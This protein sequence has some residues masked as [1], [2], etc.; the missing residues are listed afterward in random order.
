MCN[1]DGTT[2]YSGSGTKYW[3]SIVD[4]SGLTSTL[5]TTLAAGYTPYKMIYQ[6]ANPS[7]Y[8]VEEGI[9]PQILTAY[10]SGTVFIDPAIDVVYTYTDKITFA[11]KVKSLEHIEKIDGTA[12]TEIAT[13]SA[14]LAADGMSM[15][16]SGATAGTKYRVVALTL[17]ESNAGISL[18]Y[19]HPADRASQ[20]DQALAALG[21]HEDRLD[22]IDKVQLSYILDFIAHTLNASNPHTVTKAQVGLGDVDNAQQATKSEFD[23]HTGA[24]NPHNV[25]KADVGLGNVTND[26]QATKTAFDAHTA[27][28]LNPH[29]VTKAQV[30]LG[31]VDNAK[32]MPIAGGTFTGV[33]VA[34][35]NTQYSTEQLHNVIVS[36]NAPS[37]TPNNGT[38]W[39]RYK[40]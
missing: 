4:G 40:P 11:S 32:Q 21:I 5:P 12:V 20:I 17:S 3:K 35:S 14:T 6:L 19:S 22:N 8:G 1:S 24:A 36:S 38:I 18:K 37:G 34:N 25:T 16:I 30:G 7:V 29:T 28:A 10:P 31:S 26:Q 2:P 27:N 23:A 9:Q 15:T 39:L 13:T 33:A